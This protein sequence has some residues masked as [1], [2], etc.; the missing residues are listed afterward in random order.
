MGIKFKEGI[1]G[2]PNGRPKG[3][4]NKFRFDV[5]EILADLNCNPFQILADLAQTAR[6]EKV[7]CEAAGEL[8]SYVAPKLKALEL[9]TDKESPVSFVINLAAQK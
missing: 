3:S 1:S 5:A 2:N 7:R 9:S 4:K 8:A 6:S